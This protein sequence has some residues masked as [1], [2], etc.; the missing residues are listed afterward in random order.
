M[1]LGNLIPRG[2]F[3][4]NTWERIYDEVVSTAKDTITISGLNG[5]VDNEYK[6]ICSFVDGGATTSDYQLRLNNDT[7]S[8]YGTQTLF[9]QDTT[10][11]AQRPAAQT[12]WFIAGAVGTTVGTKFHNKLILRAKSGYVRTALNE[13]VRE[14][15][16]TT[17]YG[18]S[19]NGFSWNNIVD[20]ITSLDLAS[21]ITNGIGVGSR[22]T[23]W[24]KVLIT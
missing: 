21:T 9:G 1:K 18:Y 15:T 6:L 8:N 5:D 14:V 24:R 22:V 12:R 17:V 7:G 4:A 3:T 19:L 10:I 13:V 11:G 16:G 2:Q 20:N 23:L